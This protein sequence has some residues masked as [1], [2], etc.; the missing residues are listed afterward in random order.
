MVDLILHPQALIIGFIIAVIDRLCILPEMGRFAPGTKYAVAGAAQET[1]LVDGA[2]GWPCG[3]V[4][5]LLAASTAIGTRIS[6]HHARIIR[7]IMQASL[8]A[9]DVENASLCFGGVEAEF[10]MSHGQIVSGP[11]ALNVDI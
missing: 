7:S 5:R 10:C 1:S 3:P 2:Q 9:H 4:S 11:K 8:P 6:R